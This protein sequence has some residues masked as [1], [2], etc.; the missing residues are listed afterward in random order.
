MCQLWSGMKLYS[1][2]SSSAN[3]KSQL[4]VKY[5]EVT[6]SSERLK[7]GLTTLLCLFAL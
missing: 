5:T 6:L 2:S 4:N 7:T 1:V 3:S